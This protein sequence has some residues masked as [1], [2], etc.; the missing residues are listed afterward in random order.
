M[1]FLG[2]IMALMYLP[3]VTFLRPAT[4]TTAACTVLTCPDPSLATTRLARTARADCNCRSLLSL[5]ET[6]VGKPF[7]SAVVVPLF[8]VG[9]RDPLTAKQLLMR[10]E[11]LVFDTIGV[12]K[13]ETLRSEE[14]RRQV[15][16]FVSAVLSHVCASK[17]V[18]PSPV[19]AFG[20]TPS[21]VRVSCTIVSPYRS[22]QS[23]KTACFRQ[24]V[25]LRL[26]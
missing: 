22:M 7:P 8:P 1:G 19:P 5:L 9:K 3:D 23:A 20:D 14:P 26:D 25:Q 13:S 21:S 2:I 12:M 17:S 18:H 6:H 15:S 10:L 4:S 24:S 16:V 11:I